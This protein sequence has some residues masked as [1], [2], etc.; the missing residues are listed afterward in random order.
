MQAVRPAPA[1]HHAPGKF[2]NDNHLPVAH[3]V[4]NITL[5][6]LIRLDRLQHVMPVFDRL[7]IVKAFDTEEFR[8]FLLALVGERHRLR[9]LVGKIV[10]TLGEVHTAVLRI[11]LVL[12]RDAP[13]AK[14]RDDLVGPVIF[15][16]GLLGGTGDDQRRA[17]LVD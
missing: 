14:F 15:V 17:R 5:E 10:V 11:D 12:I 13:A 1:G 9:L 3:D 7:H 16:G 4:I 2:V 8:R 6:E